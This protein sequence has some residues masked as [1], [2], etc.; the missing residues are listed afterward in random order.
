MRLDKSIVSLAL[1]AAVPLCG[2]N[3]S[4]DPLADFQIAAALQRADFD[5]AGLADV[6]GA[7]RRPFM[8]YLRAKAEFN[9]TFRAVLQQ[10]ENGRV[11]EQAGAAA[12]AGGAA[13]AAE[14][15]GISGLLTAALESGAMT[16]T[17]DQNLLT[18]RGNAEG[19]YRFVTGQDV[20]PTCFS[21][22]ETGCDPSPFNNLELTASFDVSKSNTAAVTG[23][24][25]LTGAQ[26]AALVTSDKRQFSS[27]SARYVILNSRDLRSATY[28]KAW[29]DWYGKNRSALAAV[30]ADL[31]KALDAVFDKVARTKATD[32]AGQALPGDLTLYEV[33][34]A[35]AK[36]ALAA[37]PRTEASLRAVL[38]RQLDL[39]E[40]Q[41][42]NLD[43]DLD[44]RVAGAAN[45]YARYFDLTRQGFEL[46]N[47][48]MLTLEATYSQPTLQ[49]KLINAKVAFAWSPKARGTLNPGTF[50]LN[51]GVSLYTK[52][53]PDSSKG[54]TSSWRD[55]QFAAQFD[56][57]I[58]GPGAPAALSLGGYFQYQMSPGLIQI[59]AGSV[60]PGT[61]VPL[62]G[63]ATQLLA[64][65]GTIG[66]A[67]ASITLH[68][69]NSGIKVPI[70][71]SWSNRTEL[72]TG[73]EIRGHIGFNFDSHSLLLAGH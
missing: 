61:N 59:P 46:G 64:K 73:S 21:A 13:S 67:Y 43:P 63:D 7:Y 49:P 22:G 40:A 33:W 2:Q 8:T 45:A 51:A 60:A 32:A 50:T 69:P 29:T 52:P 15:A 20:I 3:P 56:R 38:M 34:H 11:D 57:P 70:G 37:A 53:Q 16:Q 25:P 26:V 42:R 4:A 58:G 62:P 66:V 72:L 27:A 18:L 48:P 47:M 35:S 65:K 9:G 24:N 41:M 36:A 23:E 44:V 31:L 39:L 71:I 55:A 28:R 1:C 30:G 12:S 5:P 19:L 17:F 6:F 68:L 10:I 14:K 54:T